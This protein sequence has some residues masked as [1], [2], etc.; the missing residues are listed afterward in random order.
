MTIKLS[1]K[2]G[3][4]FVTAF[5]LLAA[6]V[7]YAVT[8]ISR[9]VE[10]FVRVTAT[11][12]GDKALALYTDVDGQTGD[13]LTLVDFGTVDVDP[14]G[15]PSQASRVRVWVQNGSNTTYKLAVDD[16]DPINTGDDTF[17]FGEVLFAR[18]GDAPSTAPVPDIV[19]EPG[20]LVAIDLGLEFTDVVTGDHTFTVRFRAVE[21]SAVNFALEFDATDDLVQIPD[22]ESLDSDVITV[23]AWVWRTGG[24]AWASKYEVTTGGGNSWDIHHDNFYISRTPAENEPLGYSSPTGRWVHIATVYDGSDQYVYIDGVLNATRPWPGQ[25]NL[26]TS[27]VLIGSGH[28][29]QYWGGLID[30]V[31]IWNI[32]R[33]Q[34]QIQAAMNSR[35]VGDEPGLMGYWP[36][37]EGGGQVAGD[38]SGNGNNGQLGNSSGIDPADPLWVASGAP[39]Q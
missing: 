35:L 21:R 9:G 26:S 6:G 17:A 29:G 38:A 30:E 27:P 34:A 15:N 12:T 7:A 14:F 36:F 11:I 10:G 18:S 8:S 13:R 32:A 19:L 22:S 24:L 16:Q 39:V 37:D 20:D 4:L 23:E 2:S 33:T 5:L 1:L 3:I 25:I 28:F 31:R